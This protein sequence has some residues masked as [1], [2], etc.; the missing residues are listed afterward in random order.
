MT[1]KHR[2]HDRLHLLK[3]LHDE[4]QI[5]D[6]FA[7]VRPQRMLQALKEPYYPP[8]D[9]DIAAFPTIEAPVS[10]VH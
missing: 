6:A 10:A 9:L 4:G 3:I 1:A 8:N 7:H 5:T 2:L